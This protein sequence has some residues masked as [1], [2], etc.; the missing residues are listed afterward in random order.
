MKIIYKSFLKSFKPL[1][2]WKYLGLALLADFLFFVAMITSWLFIKNRLIQNYD[3]L[4][5]MSNSINPDAIV[6]EES[7]QI[8]SGQLDVLKN[9]T[10]NIFLN[11]FA[12]ILLIFIS[13]V[14]FEGV[15]WLVAKNI[16]NKEKLKLRFNYFL[17]FSGLTLFWS[18]VLL[19]L[20]IIIILN[21][22]SDAN[23]TSGMLIFFVAYLLVV[24][25]FS[26][27]S[28]AYFINTEKIW[29]SLKDSLINGIKG[30]YIF[31][32]IFLIIFFISFLVSTLIIFVI[33]FLILK[34]FGIFV[35]V[36]LVS[37]IFMIIFFL[38]CVWMSKGL[39]AVND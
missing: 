25:Y 4:Q 26:T 27:I 1:S 19:L 30:I 34:L 21:I 20:F 23:E 14:I 38:F 29:K 11:L 36:T 28:Y 37:F 8:L 24:I 35:D 12:F 32:P 5:E 16:I 9:A 13:F 7:L 2:N 6:G 22:S 39:V 3:I 17:K 18:L 15:S 31:V 10:T 33:F